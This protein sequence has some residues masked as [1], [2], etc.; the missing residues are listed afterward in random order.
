MPTRWPSHNHL[1]LQGAIGRLP[2]PPVNKW[3]R[4]NATPYE[5][6]NA[7]TT[8]S[9]LPPPRRRLLLLWTTITAT[10]EGAWRQFGLLLFQYSWSN[11]NWL[12]HERPIAIADEVDNNSMQAT[13]AEKL[14]LRSCSTAALL[15]S[16]NW[17]EIRAAGGVELVTSCEVPST[18][19][20]RKA[21]R[22]ASP[23][24]NTNVHP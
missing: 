13:G 15:L 24:G 3:T 18:I 17:R 10:I 23:K 7:A 5:Q 6:Q 9:T 11:D 4:S 16:Y 14:P 20:S 21:S 12:L 8:V 1:Y 19:Q 22:E 2:H